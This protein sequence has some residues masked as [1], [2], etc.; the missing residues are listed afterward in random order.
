MSLW[1]PA[2]DFL[3]SVIR[4]HSDPS[5]MHDLLSFS[6]AIFQRGPSMFYLPDCVHVTNLFGRKLWEGG[7]VLSSNVYY[8][9]IASVE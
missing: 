1:H 4:A 5:L 8:R 3:K 6:C 7:S 9:R 2:N